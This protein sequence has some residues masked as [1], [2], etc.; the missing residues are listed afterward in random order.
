MFG[1]IMK[2]WKRHPNLKTTIVGGI[3]GAVT[4]A[5]NGVFGP[6]GALIAGA[7]SAIYGLF[8][9]RPQDSKK[10]ADEDAIKEFAKE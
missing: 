2:W 10:E 6:K 5:A 8:V 3:G 1:K 7:A 4:L 9:K